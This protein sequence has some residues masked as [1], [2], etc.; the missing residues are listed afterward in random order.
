MGL[1][2]L[3][4]TPNTALLDRSLVRRSGN[5]VSVLT[6]SRLV[7]GVIKRFGFDQRDSSDL[8]T[9]AVFVNKDIFYL[10]V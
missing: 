6:S 2:N 8:T 10:A 3:L 7:F 4:I 9:A 1:P 5:Y